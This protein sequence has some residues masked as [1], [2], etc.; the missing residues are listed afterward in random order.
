VHRSVETPVHGQLP[1]VIGE[2]HGCILVH[3]GAE[4]RRIPGMQTAVGEGVG[5]GEDLAGGFAVARVLL[6]PEVRYRQVECGA[7]AIATGD[8]PLGPCE[9]VCTP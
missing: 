6:D 8:R 7:A 2:A 1:G 4:A 9:P 3:A 5:G